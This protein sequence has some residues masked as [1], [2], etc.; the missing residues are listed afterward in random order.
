MKKL[1]LLLPL[2]V[3]FG[4]PVEA[5]QISLQC[6]LTTSTP[7]PVSG[8]NPGNGSQGTPIYLGAGAINVMT[9]QIYGMFGASSNFKSTGTLLSTDISSRWTDAS[10]SGGGALQLLFNGHC[11]TGSGTPAGSSGQFQ[12]NNA[13][14]FGAY[15]A[16]QAIGQLNSGTT[17]AQTGTTYTPVIGDANLGITNSNASAV[18]DTI[19][20]NSSVAYLVG[21]ILT[22]QNIGANI[23]TVSPGSG[24]TFQGAI[25]GSSTSQGYQLNSAYS[26]IQLQKTATDTWNVN[27]WF[28]PV[29]QG[30]SG[31]TKFTTSGTCTNSATAGDATKGTITMSSAGNCTIIVTIN[32][33]VGATAKTG[34]VGTM[35]DRTQPTIPAWRETAS[36]ATT[37]TFTVPTAVASSDVVSFGRLDWY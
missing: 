33:A 16:A 23:A 13:G 20:P 34:W 35:A 24:V 22:F 25:Y 3:L 6:V 5:Q 1:L 10:C 11:G 2:L 27:Y 28:D 8:S 7:C 9:G 36:S 31:G 29:L 37:I 19:P 4:K 26:S 30:G 18:T 14:S 21:T 12:Y 15:T 32:G 17:N